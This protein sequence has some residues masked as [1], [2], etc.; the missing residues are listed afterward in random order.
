MSENIWAGDLLDR[1]A[2]AMYLQRYLE[3]IYASSNKSKDSSF[4][5]NINSEWG[6]GKTWFLERLAKE[7]KTNYPVVY[8]D[9][10]KNDF[11]KDALLSFVSVICTE[12]ESQFTRKTKISK[13]INDVKNAFS[14]YAEKA[15]PIIASVAVK[16]ITGMSLEN[17]LEQPLEKEDKKSMTD[18]A[19]DLAKIATNSAVESF[20]KAKSAINQFEAAIKAL[21][22]EI[23]NLPIFIFVDE[24]DRCRPTYAIELLESIKHLF[25]TQG[26]FFIIATDTKQLS[27]SIKAVYGNDFSSISYLKRFFY[28]EYQLAEPNYKNM[29][30]FLFIDFKFS[31]KLFMPTPLEN[32]YGFSDF[33]GKTT[34]FFKLTARDQEQV[35]NILKTILM[36]YKGEKI[37][38]IFMLF[39]I[40]IKHKFEKYSGDISNAKKHLEEIL[41][42]STFSADI[43]HVKIR[44]AFFDNEG[45]TNKKEHSMRDIFNFYVA[46]L[47]ENLSS[48]QDPLSAQEHFV[49]QR[50]IN[51]YLLRNATRN[52]KNGKFVGS[53]E[54]LSYFELLSQAGRLTVN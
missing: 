12:L 13:K 4:V 38:Y 29:A 3:N 42:S 26:I 14:L 37:H 5:L 19:G 39:L 9:A 10:W 28:A 40:C 53:N 33:F 44:S 43:K 30:D 16:Q 1:K 36:A 23:K 15:L 17:L 35:F 7:L 52:P 46:R 50:E 24:L 22:N 32:E 2:E 25:G 27:H 20:T 6:H 47:T 51:N 31:E 49:Y 34:E 41:K 45:Y 11:T 18:G 54:L 48:F 21:I 8:F